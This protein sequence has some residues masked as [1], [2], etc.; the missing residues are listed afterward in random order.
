MID[1]NSNPDCKIFSELPQ[2]QLSF[3]FDFKQKK[4]LHNIDTFY[5]SVKFTEDFTSDSTDTA[6][7][8]FRQ[9][10]A[11]YKDKLSKSFDSC[12]S[13]P[14]HKLN[15]LNVVPLSFAHMYNF[16]LQRPDEFDIIFAP[17]VPRGSGEVSVTCECVVQIRSGYLWNYGPVE[18]FERT[19]KYVKALS[20]RFGFHIAFTQENRCDYCWHTNYILNPAKFFNPENLY[21]LRVDRYNDATFHTVKNGSENYDLDYIAIG[22]RSNKTFIRIYLKTKEVI[23]MNYKPFFFKTWFLHGL[24]NRYDLYCYEEAYKQKKFNYLYIARLKWYLEHGSNEAIKDQCKYYI[25]QYE[26]Y[27]LTGDNLQKFADSITPKLNMIINVEFQ[28]MRKGSKSYE[29]VPFRDNSE[30]GINKRIYD[31]FDNHAVITEYLTRCTFRLVAGED[32]NKSRRDFHPFW[33]AL[34][35]TKLI[36]CKRLKPE[37]IPKK[38]R[39]YEKKLNADVVKQRFINSAVN[40]GFYSK[41]INDQPAALDVMQAL[42]TLNDNDIKKAMRYKQKRKKHLSS[43]FKEIVPELDPVELLSFVDKDGIIYDQDNISDFFGGIS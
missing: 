12:V 31:F 29:L 11:D 21:K 35:S 39:H 41:G 10:V 19:F 1:F 17:V 5:Y 8:K 26:L 16:W 37:Q 34:R 42:C 20:D 38:F 7:I 22:K 15:S 33:K 23:E 9:L 36:D 18:A 25:D 4:F 32:Q 40:L 24:I 3:W 28:N 6:V 13:F 27:S 14:L 43:E 30:K 2:E